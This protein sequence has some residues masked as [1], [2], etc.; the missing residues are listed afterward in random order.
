MSKVKKVSV[1]IIF[2]MQNINT[3]GLN[4][5]TSDFQS[6]QFEHECLT[7]LFKIL[8]TF[9]LHRLFIF[10]YSSRDIFLYI[11]KMGTTFK[12][13][14]IIHVQ[15][16]AI[17]TKRENFLPRCSVIGFAENNKLTGLYFVV[18]TVS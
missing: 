9:I 2:I 7:F 11:L 8:P 14:Q 3:V 5:S 18:A 17:K 10:I 13:Q 4:I 1:F 16:T 15:G 6:N 12:V